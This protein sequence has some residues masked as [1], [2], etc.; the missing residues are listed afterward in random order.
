M[1]TT[2]NYYLKAVAS[3]ERS[4]SDSLLFFT[5]RIVAGDDV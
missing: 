3:D 1:T 5:R 4:V 2:M